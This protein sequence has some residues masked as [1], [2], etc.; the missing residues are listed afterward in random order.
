MNIVNLL[1]VVQGA[2]GVADLEVAECGNNSNIWTRLNTINSIYAK[3][4]HDVV[5]VEQFK[6]LTKLGM[7][8]QWLN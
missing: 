2:N 1:A 4:A 8:M 6:I 7:M 5:D 3:I